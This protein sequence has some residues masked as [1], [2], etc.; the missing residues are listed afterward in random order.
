MTG[1]T[2]TPAL[3]VYVWLP[4]NHAASCDGSLLSVASCLYCVYAAQTLLCAWLLLAAMLAVIT[5]SLAN[6]CSYSL[7]SLWLFGTALTGIVLA[8]RSTLL[9]ALCV[10]LLFLSCS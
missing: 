10:E 9:L 2:G 5:V 6:A 1:T 8:R 7:L 3:D 4:L